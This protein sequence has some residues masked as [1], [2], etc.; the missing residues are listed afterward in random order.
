[1]KIKWDI[2]K[3]ANLCPIIDDINK[4]IKMCLYIFI[5][6]NGIAWWSEEVYVTITDPQWVQD[7]SVSYLPGD[8]N[9]SQKKPGSV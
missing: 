5:S 7:H 3:N 6:F 9:A 8:T 2:F 4:I 1:M